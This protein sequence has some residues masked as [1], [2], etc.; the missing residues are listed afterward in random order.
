MERK[1][2]NKNT[3]MNTRK[4]FSNTYRENNVPSSKLPFQMMLPKL[5]EERKIIL[6]PEEITEIRTRQVQNRSISEYLIRGNFNSK[7]SS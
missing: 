7:W 2:E 4:A 6:E 5:D 1:V 3:A